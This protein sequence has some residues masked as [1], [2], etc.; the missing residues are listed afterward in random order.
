MPKNFVLFANILAILLVDE[1]R[2]KRK[3]VF[4]V[5]TADHTY[6]LQAENEENMTEW[7]DKLKKAI[8]K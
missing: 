1:V 3:F 4:E 2:Y 6:A 8:K 5:V 7:V